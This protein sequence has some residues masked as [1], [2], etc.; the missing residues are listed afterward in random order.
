[1]DIAN[2]ILRIRPII[3]ILPLPTIMHAPNLVV[4]PDRTARGNADISAM[5]HAIPQQAHSV[6]ARIAAHAVVQDAKVEAVLERAILNQPLAR[7]LA[8]VVDQ[9]V[10]EAQV[11]L[12]IRVLG[13]GAQQDYVAQAL[14]LPMHALDAVVFVCESVA[15]GSVVRYDVLCVCGGG[16]GDC[17]VRTFR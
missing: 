9:A 8:V 16:R 10:C 5:L 3:A 2:Q 4:Q 12:R 13:G 17:E 1:M 15:R 14:G 6:R 11:Q 7:Y